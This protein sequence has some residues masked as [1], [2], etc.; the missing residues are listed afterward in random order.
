MVEPN[1]LKIDL[2]A[3]PK[4]WS[5]VPIGE[6]FDFKNG[7]NKAKQ[8]FGYGKPIINYM[9][10]FE[11]SGI[12]ASQIKGKVDVDANE[13]RTFEVKKGD[14]LFT[15]TSETVNEIGI[16]CT[17]LD[18]VSE[19]VFSGFVLRGRPK[20]NKL[21]NLFKKYV[22][23]SDSVRKQIISKATYTTRALT[24]GRVL[25]DILIPVPNFE[26][27]QLAIGEALSDTDELIKS[28]KK[29]IK[30]KQQIYNQFLHNIFLDYTVTV[31]SK[32][33]TLSEFGD[34]V[35][36]IGFPLKFQGQKFEE[37][38]FFK[39]SDFNLPLNQRRL[40]ISNN[41]ISTIQLNQLGGRL[42]KKGSIIFAKIGAAI[43]LERKRQSTQDSMVDNNV[44]AFEINFHKA[45]E[46]FVY[47]LFQFIKLSKFC[48]NSALPSIDLNE[49]KR[50]KVNL[51]ELDEQKTVSSKL[52]NF[53]S[54]IELLKSRLSKL[55]KIK[56][57]MM[58]DLLIGRKRL[59]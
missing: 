57:G 56:V 26:K 21:N 36:G 59:I 6:H 39:V 33:K 25:S 3:L 28:L 9:D 15:R 5:W 47:F 12:Y 54:E 48:N 43:F 13:L 8:F 10:V 37:I 30:K 2:P 16:S 14:V 49:L 19:T 17:V 27:E 18:E 31:S 40:E 11:F 1:I 52:N 23:S 42:I 55:K 53:Y 22:F 44:A 35:S 7:L 51:P 29:L 50:F 38:P 4:E 20:N 45:D 46:D 58:Q 34:F 24:N 41:Y 32:T